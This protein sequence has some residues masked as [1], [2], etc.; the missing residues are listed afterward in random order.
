[1]VIGGVDFTVARN[2]FGSQMAGPD[3][4]I[5]VRVVATPCRQAAATLQELERKFAAGKNVVKMGVVDALERKSG[6]RHK[7]VL[8][9]V[10]AEE[11]KDELLSLSTTG[12]TL[13]ELSGAADGTS[14]REVICAVRKGRLLCPAFHPELTDDYR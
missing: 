2:S 12:S 6:L 11:K 5:L 10:S 13:I 14:A 9:H 7:S 8:S 3:V 4:E 1:L